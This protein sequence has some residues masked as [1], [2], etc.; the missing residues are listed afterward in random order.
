MI[1]EPR[2]PKACGAEIPGRAAN[3][4]PPSVGQRRGTRRS[5]RRLVAEPYRVLFPLAVLA[6]MLGVGHWLAYAAGWS[7]GYSGLFHAGVQMQVY[8]TGF[9]AGFLMTAMPRF[10][11]ARPASAA[12]T[13]GTTLLLLA[14]L[15]F[16]AAG[17]WVLAQAAFVAVLLSL[18]AFFARRLAG[19]RGRR[20]G[21]DQR[22]KAVPP[23]ELVW[24]PFALLHGLAGAALLAG[25]QG[26]WLSARAAATGRSMLQEG[27]VLA[28]VV[29]VGGFLAPRLMGTYRLPG[30]PG[31]SAASPRPASASGPG[32]GGGLGSDSRAGAGSG[33]KVPS[34]RRRLALHAAG[35]AL[36][37]ASFAAHGFGLRHEADLFRAVLLTGFLVASRTVVPRPRIGDQYV[38]YVWIAFWMVALGLWAA[39][40]LPDHRVAALHLVFVGGYSLMTFAVATMVVASHA[41]E[42]KRL[43]RPAWPLS[44]T[45][46]GVL[47]ALGLRL[48]AVVWPGRYFE[49]LGAAAVAWLVA[50]AA[51]LAYVAPWLVRSLSPA[52]FDRMHEESKLRVLRARK[53]GPV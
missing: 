29:G 8:V 52:A 53:A 47:T 50:A 42:A 33:T 32:S 20:G 48:A 4:D 21:E 36:L 23:V 10:A 1:P 7:G 15:A 12:E 2:S 49:L 40:L 3:A 31:R 28:V 24:V 19:R 11:G 39:A 43:R 5:V 13:W 27:F 18:V 25:G 16:F 17:L 45:A 14:V 46:W 35:G 9:I 51:W 34:A 44:L 22:P 6:G 38:R 41:G 30:G 26:G 37:L